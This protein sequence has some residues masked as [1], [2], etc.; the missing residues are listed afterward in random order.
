MPQSLGVAWL[1]RE[2]REKVKLDSAEQ[3]LRRPQAKAQPED[4]VGRDVRRLRLSLKVELSH[5][6]SGC[7]HWDLDFGFVALTFRFR[8]M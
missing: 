3:C 7:R 4:G 8:V 5:A 1:G 6:G 2:H